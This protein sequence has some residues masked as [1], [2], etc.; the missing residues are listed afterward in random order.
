MSGMRKCA[1]GF[2]VQSDVNNEHG[3]IRAAAVML[4]RRNFPPPPGFTRRAA[5]LNCFSIRYVAVA[6]A[7]VWEC[8]MAGYRCR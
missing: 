7:G 8:S 5:C 3:L 2:V 4:C 1:A 6:P